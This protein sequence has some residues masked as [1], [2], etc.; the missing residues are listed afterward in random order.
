[1]IDSL[2]T[3]CPLVS[4]QV[5]GIFN[6]HDCG[7]V[8]RRIFADRADLL[9]CQILADLTESH[10]LLGAADGVR[11]AVHPRGGHT[12]DMKGET[13]RRFIA[14]ARQGSELVDQPVNIAGI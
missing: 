5:A 11:Q 7:L 2:K 12:Y 10:V 8:A 4:R 3:T 6:N 14:D 9:V 1:M 13:L